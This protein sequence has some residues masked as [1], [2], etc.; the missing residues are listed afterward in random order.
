VKAEKELEDLHR[1]IEVASRTGDN[2]K[3]AS[4]SKKIHAC[5]KVIEIGF[6]MLEATS[7]EYH[8]EKEIFD[9]KFDE[10]DRG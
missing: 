9:R 8:K 7:V 6:A 3:I 1:E 10:L 4:L 2:A 5:E